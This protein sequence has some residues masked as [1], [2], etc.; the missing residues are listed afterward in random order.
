MSKVSVVIPTLNAADRIGGLVDILKAQERV[1]DEIYVVDSSSQDGTADAARE[2]GARVKVIDRSAFNHGLTRH[3][4]VLE[5]SGDFVCFLTDDAV[6]AGPA[7]LGNLL[8]P[9]ADPEVALVSGRQLPKAD[10]RRFEQLVRGF[11]YGPESNVRTLGDLPRY[12]IKTYFATDVCSAYRRSA[13]LGA[14]GFGACDM[15]EDMLMA[16]RFINAGYKVAYAADAEVYHSHN[17]GAA[18]QY[19]RNELIGRFLQEHADELGNVAE[20]GEG[21]S[22]AKSIAGQLVKEK[23]IPELLAFGVDCVARLAGNRAGRRHARKE[24]KRQ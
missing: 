15:S 6:P 22:L 10:A 13:Y 23:D 1:P 12:G 20:V 11:N 14:G 19:R 16:A 3:E 2:R 5:T 4:A 8:A 21:S 24:A 7:Y 18:Q 9:F 17:L